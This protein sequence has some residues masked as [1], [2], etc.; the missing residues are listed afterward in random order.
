LTV[1]VD[2]CDA[3]ASRSFNG[4]LSVVWPCKCSFQGPARV[5]PGGLPG[6]SLKTQQYA[7]ALRQA[8]SSARGAARLPAHEAPAGSRLGR[9]SR[10]AVR[11]TGSGGR[12]PFGSSL[13]RR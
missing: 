10:C 2:N 1:I 8:A 11:I 9:R 5:P 12:L 7:P 3:E 6:W 13:E 4:D